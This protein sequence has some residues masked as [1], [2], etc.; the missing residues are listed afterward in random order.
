MNFWVRERT[1]QNEL[2]PSSTQ[3]IGD[4]FLLANGKRWK[5][6]RKIASRMFS[7]RNL[8]NY[9]V[10]VFMAQSKA[11]SIKM[12]ELIESKPN[13]YMDMSN[14]FARLTL[15]A[16]VE[17]LYVLSLSLSSRTPSLV[18]PFHS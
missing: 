5:A 4:G 10:E 16:F 9:M 2:H 15:G 18:T 3:K 11:L 13:E 8:K 6:Q 14:L 12:N 1:F 7:M 17:G